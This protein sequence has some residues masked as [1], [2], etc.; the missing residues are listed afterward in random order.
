MK[1]SS[2]IETPPH[3][4]LAPR[5]GELRSLSEMVR[6]IETDWI[7]VALVVSTCLFA[8]GLAAYILHP[9]GSTLV[10]SSDRTWEEQA[11]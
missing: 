9:S 3:A 10:G 11:P 7:I 6:R 8:A 4:R 1:S 2:L 5:I